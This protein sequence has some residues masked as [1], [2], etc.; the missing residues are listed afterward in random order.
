MKT[1]TRV[2]AMLLTVLMVVGILPLSLFALDS[3]E[4][5]D[6]NASTNPGA[7]E[8]RSLDDIKTE[9]AKQNVALGMYMSFGKFAPDDYVA[10]RAA[11]KT[12]WQVYVGGT[13][14]ADL[15]EYVDGGT[16]IGICDHK[17]SVSI[18]DGAL[19]FG[20]TLGKKADGY[21]LAYKEG[22]TTKYKDESECPPDKTPY[23]GNQETYLQLNAFPGS[24]SIA[25]TYIS[26]DVKMNG[27]KMSV[28]DSGHFFTIVWRGTGPNFIH[29]LGVNAE[30]ELSIAGE[31]VGQLSKTEYT[32]LTLVI[33][34][35]D[36]KY[37]VYVND[38]IVNIGGTQL[39]TQADADRYNAEKNPADK[40]TINTMPIE[41]VRAY[42]INNNYDADGV[43]DG[44]FL[45]NIVIGK[46]ITTTENKTTTPNE[47]IKSDFSNAVSGDP[48]KPYTNAF[49]TYN[50]NKLK[51]GVL[52]ARAVIY[53]DEDG[54]GKV[55]YIKC[56]KAPNLEG[57]CTV[58]NK[59]SCECDQVYVHICSGIEAVSLSLDLEMGSAA[60]KGSDSFIW[61]RYKSTEGEAWAEANKKWNEEKQQWEKPD[62]RRTRNVI[63]I[64]SDGTVKADGGIVIGKLSTDGFVNV[65]VEFIPYG[66]LGFAYVYYVD[67]VLK[68]IN[69]YAENI[70][71]HQGFRIYN[72]YNNNTGGLAED[73]IH[74]KN[75]VY[76]AINKYDNDTETITSFG[77][78]PFGFITKNG[79][80][81]YYD[82]KGGYMTDDFF[83]GSTKYMVGKDGE[84]LNKVSGVLPQRSLDEI[85][86]AFADQNIDLRFYQTF[87]N[88][89]YA[90]GRNSFYSE[91]A[92][93]DEAQ[94]S[95]P[96]KP[97][98]KNYASDT[99]YNTAVTEYNAD[100]VEFN[101]LLKEKGLLSTAENSVLW[102]GV[103]KQT[104]TTG[105]EYSYVYGD[106]NS[107]I[108][109]FRN[110]YSVVDD[111]GNKALFMNYAGKTAVYSSDGKDE[112]RDRK[113]VV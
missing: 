74:M 72:L 14:N 58:C 95:I 40:V 22:E 111:N 84:I 108:K 49:G 100:V 66:E 76:N 31:Q 65:K 27:D 48:V 92:V 94:L 91:K 1:K 86:K 90:D 88:W 105:A 25:E 62:S 85:K 64:D 9:F 75:I 13:E 61:M 73:D 15:F 71:E 70:I 16:K 6:V 82:G 32:R 80:T 35:T 109:N 29:A 33:S 53:F 5:L 47:Y 103:N 63:D 51:D 77:K 28:P 21:N 93:A 79:I 97:L 110:A 102:L 3:V 69:Y 87:T 101:A 67:G 81:R 113:S 37:F 83:I 55:D 2:L 99:A 34:R 54:D 60:I 57:K 112:D 38:V 78:M 106:R 36:N 30:G 10:K 26:I 11:A 41:C 18:V 52:D 68:H 56:Q 39:L 89:A 4:P 50:A 24:S 107:G 44:V 17:K 45:D 46:K 12:S 20:N 7:Y 8:E 96:T 43:H 23:I 19:Y 98:R 104:I 42:I 59:N